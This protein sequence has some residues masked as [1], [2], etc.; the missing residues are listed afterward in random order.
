MEKANKSGSL[1]VDLPGFQPREL[2][3]LEAEFG[4]G[5]YHQETIQ[6][7]SYLFST[8][9]RRMRDRR[10][11][12]VMIIQ[13][14]Q[15]CVLIHRKTWYE[16]GL[17][18]L[19][20]GGIGIEEPIPDALERELEE[21]TGLR[22]RECCLLAIVACDLVYGNRTLRFPSILFHITKTKGHLRVPDTDEDISD[23]QSVPIPKLSQ[24]A[25][26]LLRTPPP[27]SA[28][29]TW[30]AAAHKIAFELLKTA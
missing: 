19:P 6:A 25:A 4:R 9:K 23:F 16:P 18:R 3:L 30:R 11:E 2:H 5:A 1:A 14:P 10:G 8:R 21:E 22:I 26:R 24:I 7:D 13:Q 29:G 27:R 20:S 28:W 15:D 17:Y 12:V